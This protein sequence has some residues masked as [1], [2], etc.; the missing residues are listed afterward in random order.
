VVSLAAAT[1]LTWYGAGRMGCIPDEWLPQGH[2]HFLFALLF[3]ISVVVIACPCAL[4]LATPTAVMVGTG[5]GASLGVLIKG[6]EALERAQKV[7]CVV[8]DKTGTLTAGRPVVSDHWVAPGSSLEEVAALV[9]ALE[10]ETNHPLAGALVCFAVEALQLADVPLTDGGQARELLQQSL[11][12]VAEGAETA[13]GMGLSGKVRAVRETRH[14]GLRAGGS[15]AVAVGNRALM[16][17]LGVGVPAEAERFMAAAEADA[18]TA[19]LAAVGGVAAAAFAVSDALK[20][21]AAGV[22]VALR[23]MGVEVHMLTGDN[24]RT[25]RA[26]AGSLGITHVE[27]EVLPAGKADVIRRLQAEGRTVAMVGDGINDSPAL[28]AADLGMAIGSGTDVAVEAAD[29]VLMRSDLEDVLAALD[30]SRKT[31]ARIRL[32]YLWAMGYNVVMIPVA[33]GVLYPATQIAM[34]PWMAGAAMALSS[35]S[36]V[37]SS[38]LLQRYRRPSAVLREV[39]LG[40]KGGS[41]LARALSSPLGMGRGRRYRRVPSPPGRRD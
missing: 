19:V 9:G 39:R 29:Y 8:F 41:R 21:E 3:G 34:P 18:Q 27:A 20:P 22:T 38:L 16:S 32:N 10:M 17:E 2:N 36:V 37:C 13:N 24:W 6:G 15:T 31:F 7:D 33:A 35:V 25:A 14:S 28:A 11:G 26:M 1:F 5:V 4:G 23:K 12:L 30:L 40:G